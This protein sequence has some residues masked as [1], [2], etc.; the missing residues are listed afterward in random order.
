MHFLH[1]ACRVG[2]LLPHDATGD[3]DLVGDS[4]DVGEE[5]QPHP[6]ILGWV[7]RLGNLL[8]NPFWLFV[9]LAGIV[10]VA[11][12][13]GSLIGMHATD[14]QSGDDVEVTNLLST[15]GLQLIVSEAVTNFTSFPP[16][17]VIITVML[18]VAVAE[19]S[20]LISAAVRSMVARTGPKP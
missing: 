1:V 7:E 17:G 14:P 13:L 16:L 19:H 15:D 5:E 11:S 10:L 4:K 3:P 6:G 20:G 9:C 18:G 8:P 2:S 12:W